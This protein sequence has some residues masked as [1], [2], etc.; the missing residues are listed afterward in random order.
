[1]KRLNLFLLGLAA[2]GMVFTSCESEE[3]NEPPMLQIIDAEGY[4]VDGDEVGTSEEFSVKLNGTS[5]AT[6]G[7]ELVEL[8]ILAVFNNT[9]VVDTVIDIDKQTSFAGDISFIAP[10]NAGNGKITF[11]LVDKK[12]QTAEES[13]NITFVGLTE[14][15]TKQLGAGGNVSLGSYYSVADASVMNFSEASASPEKV[16]L[17]F[18]A[19]ATNAWFFSP[20]DSGSDAI[21]VSG[22]T[23]LYATVDFA[24]ETATVSEING[25]NLTAD[26]VGVEEND[27]VV[28]ETEDGIRGVFEV[29]SLTVA[30]D[31]SVTIDI[32]VK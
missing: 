11:T 27:V 4:V 22:R 13:L 21:N 23:T 18:N 26:E 31:G 29:A 2:M 6:S 32:K 3:T 5:N 20:K 17:V 12:D 8:E 16:D 19:D 15:G 10:A 25:V 24:F 7:A 30:A 9:T 1:M 14:H 28:F